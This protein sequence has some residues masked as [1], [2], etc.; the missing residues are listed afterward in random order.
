MHWV[1]RSVVSLVEYLAYRW[2]DYWADYLVCYSDDYLALHLV[3][4]LVHHLAWNSASQK[5][6]HLVG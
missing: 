6:V 4:L 2:V 3:G 1:G 5:V